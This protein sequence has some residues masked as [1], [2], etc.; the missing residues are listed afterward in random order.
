KKNFYVIIGSFDSKTQANKYIKNLNGQE[1]KTAGIIASNG[2]VRVYAQGFVTEKSANS[3]M[4]KLRQTTKHK[5]AW[6]YKE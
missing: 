5:Q 3:Y 6:I 2:H 4:N 1:A